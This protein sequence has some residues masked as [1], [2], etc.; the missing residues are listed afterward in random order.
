MILRVEGFSNAKALAKDYCKNGDKIKTDTMLCTKEN[1]SLG[2]TLYEELARKYCDANPDDPFCGCYNVV[3]NKCLTEENKG[4]PGCKVTYPTRES[5]NKM[6]AEYKSNFDGTDKCWGN[7]CAPGTGKYV[8]EGTIDALCNK[9]IAVCIADLNVG[10]LQESGVN[11]E[12]NCGSNNQTTDGSSGEPSEPSDGS[13]ERTPAPMD[14]S[15]KSS[16]VPLTST[17]T[18]VDGVATT[19]RIGNLRKARS[20]NRC[21]YNFNCFFVFVFHV[22]V[23]TRNV[24]TLKKKSKLNL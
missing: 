7:V 9:T 19:R 15:G 20:S 12:Q 23:G 13:T 2:P 5:I 8:P 17:H 4:L 11:I 21:S 1:D 3:K 6:P 14:S 16:S 18:A 22:I 10:D 24:I